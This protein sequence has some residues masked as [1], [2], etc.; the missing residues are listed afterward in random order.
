MATA[1]YFSFLSNYLSIGDLY[2]AVLNYKSVKHEKNNLQIQKFPMTVQL[3]V[4]DMIWRIMYKTQLD[5][6]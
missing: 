3:E 5:Q 1:S 4:E 2:L 6:F